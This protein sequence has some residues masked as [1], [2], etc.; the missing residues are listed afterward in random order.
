M[1]KPDDGW[2]G[3]MIREAT[4]LVDVGA[5]LA[6]PVFYGIRVPRG[7]GKLVVIIPGFMGNDFYLMPMLNWLNRIGYSSVPSSL[8]PS[9]GCLRRSCEQV[10]N[11]IDRQLSR[12]QRTLAIIGHSRGALVAWALAAQM[13]E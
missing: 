13:Q 5:L 7:D 3:V 12:R 1:G 8:N 10:Q 6:N 2:M 9:A 4:L 11:E